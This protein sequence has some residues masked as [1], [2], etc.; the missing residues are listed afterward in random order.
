MRKRER[1]REAKQSINL[2]YYKTFA[3]NQQKYK[4]YLYKRRKKTKNNFRI[5]LQFNSI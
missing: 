3:L 4:S 1:E 5:V 2:L